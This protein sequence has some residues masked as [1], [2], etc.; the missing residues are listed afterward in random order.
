VRPS[1]EFITAPHTD[2]TKHLAMVKA[3]QKRDFQNFN[4]NAAGSSLIHSP[5]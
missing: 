5:S 3:L 4:A 2:K 1:G